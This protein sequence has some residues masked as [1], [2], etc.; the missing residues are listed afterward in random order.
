MSVTLTDLE[1]TR[2]LCILAFDDVLV[3]ETNVSVARCSSSEDQ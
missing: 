2:L 1:E 3:A